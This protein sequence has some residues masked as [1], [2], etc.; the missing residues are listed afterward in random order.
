MGNRGVSS[1]TRTKHDAIAPVEGSEPSDEDK[2]HVYERITV[3][4]EKIKILDD[5][6]EVIKKQSRFVSYSSLCFFSHAC[7][8]TEGHVASYSYRLTGSRRVHTMPGY[9]MYHSSVGTG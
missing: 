9:S 4:T 2:H 7:W 8:N 6:T 3:L 1:T 5:G